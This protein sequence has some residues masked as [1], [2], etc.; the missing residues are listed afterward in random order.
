MTK[1]LFKH[2]WDN[3]KAPFLHCVKEIKESKE[4]SEMEKRGAIKITFKKGE[5]NLIKNYRPITLLNVDLKIITKALALRI[6]NVL[7]SLI[8]PNQ[9]C[10]PGR[11]IKNNIHITQNLIDHI[12]ETDGEAAL[13]FVDQ[14]KAFDRMSHSFIFKTLERFGF[15]QNFVNW[16]KIICN[17]TK[18]FVKVNGYETHKFD[19]ERGVRQ[20][21]PL[22]GFLYVLTA[23]VLSTYIRKNK[24]IRG[25]RYKMKNLEYLEH[26]I[27][28][29]A[30]DTNVCVSN[31]KSLD[32][33]FKVFARFEKATNAKINNDKTNA[34]WIGKWKNRN[35]KPHNL[36]WT[37]E[38]VKFLGIYIGN[39]VGSSGSKKLAELNFA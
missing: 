32:K 31:I 4:L 36:K 6:S 13:V 12:N 19:I 39:K 26:K 5:R 24:K 34:L 18:S 37:S 38:S 10:V 2:F 30:D 21:C 11:Q 27:V 23:E 14:E 17:G 3:I 35:D 9:T 29:Y 1:E 22:S 16:I 8:H 33:L 25:Y 15:G 20:G 7:P 28:Q